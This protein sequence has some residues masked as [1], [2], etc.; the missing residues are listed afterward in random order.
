[1]RALNL[2]MSSGGTE[3][4][5][6]TD[7]YDNLNCVLAGS[8]R[9]L[10]ID[11]SYYPLVSHAQCGWIDAEQR[12][13]AAGDAALP[14]DDRRLKHGYGAF[15]GINVSGVD[16]TRWAC[17]AHLPFR[18]ATLGPGDCLFIPQHMIHHVASDGG[19]ERRSVAFNLWWRRPE[20]LDMRDC[21]DEHYG[22]GRDAE[23]VPACDCA[24]ETWGDRMPSPS[25]PAC[26]PQRGRR[27]RGVEVSAKQEL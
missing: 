23:P 21:V 22:S 5:V 11:S 26:S 2:W 15:S 9:F 24:F 17:W 8:K 19:S 25:Q 20:R 13:A 18:E 6:H 1:M 12:A 14:D 10:L 4:V 16:L 7:S 27:R 3:S